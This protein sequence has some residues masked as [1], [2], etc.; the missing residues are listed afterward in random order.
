MSA[1][2]RPGFV[3]MDLVDPFEVFVGPA[4]QEGAPGERCYAFQIDARHV[5]RRDV[6]HGGMLLTFADLALGAAAWDLTDRAPCVTLS[7][8][9]EFL[10]PARIGDIVEVRPRCLRRT[11]AL[12]FLR[13]DFTV[14]GEAI[15][16]AQSVWK[17]LGKD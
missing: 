7:M 10:K 5:N 9:T 15:F 17:L 13:G 8:Q 6:V 4:Y 16:A 11:R 14:E 2:P 12:L 3:A 1:W